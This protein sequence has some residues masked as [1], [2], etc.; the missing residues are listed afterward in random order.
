MLR[1]QLPLWMCGS[2]AA[3]VGLVVSIAAASQDP[4]QQA[5][6]KSGSGPASKTNGKRPM[7]KAEPEF[8]RKT[9][10]EWRRILKP[11]VYMVTRLKETEA[12]FTGKYATGHFVGTFVCACCGAELFSSQHKFDSGT[13]WPSF[14]RPLALK[15]IERA[16]DYSAPEPRVEVMCQRC[17]AHL[18]HVFNDGPPPTGWRFCINSLS[19]DLKR[20]DGQ[21]AEKQPSAKTKTKARAKTKAKS[22]ARST[23]PASKGPSTTSSQSDQDA[24]P[25]SSDSA[26]SDQ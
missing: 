8:V 5:T 6:E 2:A 9:N 16:M 19:L 12:A 13:G 21:A 23:K 24:K 3:W 26:S 10:E 20:P 11:E 22:S 17:G 15:A 4:F 18:G 14:W 25:S 7:A 1:H